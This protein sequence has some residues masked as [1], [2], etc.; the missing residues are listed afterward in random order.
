MH[1]RFVR[2]PG[3]QIVVLVLRKPAAVHETRVV[4][5][6]GSAVGVGFSPVVEARPGIG[7]G[8]EWPRGDG[9]PGTIGK[10]VATDP[11]I[12]AIIEILAA[13]GLVVGRLTG[14]H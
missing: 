6:I 5:D 12:G 8:Y 11:S 14:K 1:H 9:L 4:A 7:P 10:V 2:S 13:R 3:L